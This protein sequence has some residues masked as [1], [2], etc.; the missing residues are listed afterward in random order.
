M[1]PFLLNKRLMITSSS[2]NEVDGVVYR[3]G[4]DLDTDEYVIYD[5]IQMDEAEG[6]E[7]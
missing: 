6:G 2:L 4:V 3:L 5:D 7:E 1:N